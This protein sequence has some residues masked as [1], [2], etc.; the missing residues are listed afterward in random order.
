MDRLSVHGNY[1]ITELPEDYSR[2]IEQVKSS[3]QLVAS[4]EEDIDNLTSL[5]VKYDGVSVALRALESRL[6]FRLSVLSK[7]LDSQANEMLEGTGIGLTDYRVLNV[8]FTI[9]AVS[10]SD[11]SR[12]CAIERDKISTSATELAKQEIVKFEPDPNRRGMKVVELTQKGQSL[13]EV[14]HPVFRERNEEME[15]LLG[16]ERKAA[17]IEAVN[18]L[19]EQAAN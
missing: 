8:V 6:T 7:L 10:I 17:L 5:V 19:T 4:A 11:I 18:L 3:L 2:V 9:G 1:P 12:F 13:L 15:T 16:P 14:L